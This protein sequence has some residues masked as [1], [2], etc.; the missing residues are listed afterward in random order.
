MGLRLQL[1]KAQ[2]EAG[3][4]ILLYGDESEALTHPYL[5]RAWAK[6]GADLRVP[7]PGQAKKVA[8]IGSLDHVTR[9]LIVHTS[10][11][12][13]SSDFIAHL[14]QLDFLYG[15]QPGRAIKPVVLVE[16]N[17]PI[18]VSKLTL[19]AIEARKHWLTVEWL[20]KYAPEL[21]DIEVVWRDLKAHHLAHQTFTDANHLDRAIHAAVG[22]LN[23]E[24]RLDPLALQSQNIGVAWPAIPAANA[25]CCGRLMT[26]M[27]TPSASLAVAAF[28]FE[29][30]IVESAGHGGRPFAVP[31]RTC[32]LR[33]RQ[34]FES[35]SSSKS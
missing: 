6:R 13:R 16:D 11:T 3:D 35:R 20:P 17:G 15:P 7:A 14:E 18:H 10:P 2:A 33:A 27:S 31:V 5:A 4:I 24:R 12:K 34:K 25:I 29:I 19:K 30:A 32:A 22:A 9:Q 26:W 1:R 8:I 28:G 23:N 21:N